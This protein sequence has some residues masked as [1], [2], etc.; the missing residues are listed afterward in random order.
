MSSLNLCK[1]IYSGKVIEI[2]QKAYSELA[3]ISVE[4]KSLYWQISFARCIYGE[5]KTKLEFENFVI[6]LEATG[7]DFS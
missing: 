7:R 6:S 5:E 2:A 3:D 1:E 4:E